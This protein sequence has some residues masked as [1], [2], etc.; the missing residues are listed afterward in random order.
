MDA[1]EP[2]QFRP[3]EAVDVNLT[4]LQPVTMTDIVL[5]LEADGEWHPATV[6]EVLTD[7]RYVVEVTPLVGAIE[8]P[9]VDA[10]HLRRRS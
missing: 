8:L 6:I 4:G 7:G 2:T 5:D 10:A 9:P 3:G 1:M